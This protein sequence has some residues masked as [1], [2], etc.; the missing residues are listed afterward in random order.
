M[1][2]ASD[3]DAD[4]NIAVK[5]AKKQDADD[6]MDLWGVS[7][8]VGNGAGNGSSNRNKDKGE[9][10]SSQ[11]QPKKRAR[12]VSAG[13]ALMTPSGNPDGGEA[14]SSTGG[15]SG[16]LQSSWMF[17]N[18]LATKTRRSNEHSKESMAVVLLIC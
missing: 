13:V 1:K 2:L 7:A 12:G 9:N 6:I 14:S 8:L 16:G 15:D 17:G 5:M 11:S 3:A 18:K 4:G 10:R